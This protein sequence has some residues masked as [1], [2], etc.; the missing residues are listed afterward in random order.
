MTL[1]HAAKGEKIAGKVQ[2]KVGGEVQ[3]FGGIRDLRD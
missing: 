1:K 3:H 2:R